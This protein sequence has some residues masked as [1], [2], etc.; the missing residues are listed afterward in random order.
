LDAIGLAVREK[1]HRALVDECHVP[2][3][4][5][6]VL[7][8]GCLQVEQLSEILDIFCFNSATDREDDSAID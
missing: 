8:P 5:H 2:Q 6:Q 7:L 3:I 4:Q 1:F